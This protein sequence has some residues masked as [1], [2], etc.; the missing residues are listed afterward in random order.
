RP[1]RLLHREPVPIGF[2]TPLR[3]EFRLALL[4]R[5]DAYDIFIEP[6]RDRLLLDVGDEAVLVLPLHELRELIG[7]GCHDFLPYVAVADLLSSSLIFGGGSGSGFVC[8]SARLTDC[9]AVRMLPLI[10]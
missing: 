10:R 3:H 8:R 7:F 6:R 9:N 4:E 5:E 1:G 2:Q